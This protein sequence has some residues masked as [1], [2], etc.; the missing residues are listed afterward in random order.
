MSTG[1]GREGK[2]VLATQMTGAADPSAPK[3]SGTAAV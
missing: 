3:A 2:A 1:Q